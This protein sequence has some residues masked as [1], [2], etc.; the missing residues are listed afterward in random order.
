MELQ[1]GQL[2][3]IGSTLAQLD[4]TTLAE[5]TRRAREHLESALAA[6]EHLSPHRWAVTVLHVAQDEASVP[7]LVEALRQF[8]ERH[9]V[10]IHDRDRHTV[11]SCVPSRVLKALAEV[12]DID[13]LPAVFEAM[14]ALGNPIQIE[15]AAGVARKIAGRDGRAAREVV[16][17]PATRLRGVLDRIE[18]DLACA[19]PLEANAPWDNT[20]GTEPWRRRMA[21][22]HVAVARLL[23]TIEA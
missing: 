4:D 13:S 23:R 2:R 14:E 7:L 9:D 12:G 18:T 22:A 15:R 17:Q 1:A 16:D 19:P 8:T 20:A 21:R 11:C 10:C 6:H 5:V 3:A